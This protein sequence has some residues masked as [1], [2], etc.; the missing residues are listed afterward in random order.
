MARVFGTALLEWRGDTLRLGSGGKA[1]PTVKVA[2][3]TTYSN[4]WRVKLPSGK[5]SDMVNRARAKDAARAIL[6]GILNAEE[7]AAEAHTHAP[8]DQALVG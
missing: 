6:L 4:M 2:R 7:T 5:L 1:S 3:D 8:N